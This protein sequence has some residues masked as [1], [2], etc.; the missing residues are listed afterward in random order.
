MS[1]ELNSELLDEKLQKVYKFV[2]KSLS[3][4]IS[5]LSKLVVAS[6]EVENNPQNFVYFVKPCGEK[7]EISTRIIICFIW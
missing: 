3:D 4:S 1:K 2:V 6:N 5:K 7:R